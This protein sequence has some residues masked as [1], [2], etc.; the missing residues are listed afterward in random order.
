MREKRGWGNGDG[1][2]SSGAAGRER[3]V[4]LQSWEML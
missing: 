4:V 3:M 2:K 1:G